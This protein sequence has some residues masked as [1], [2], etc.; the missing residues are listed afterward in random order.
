MFMC[1]FM[2]MYLYLFYYYFHAYLF[3]HFL[4]QLN[5]FFLPAS[6]DASRP[7]GVITH[8]HP[9]GLQLIHLTHAYAAKKEGFGVRLSFFFVF[10]FVLVFARFV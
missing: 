5:I 1:L 10:L 7:G 8:L 4:A 6:P 2:Y 3:M 9:P